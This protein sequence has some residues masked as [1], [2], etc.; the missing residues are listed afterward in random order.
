MGGAVR[1]LSN[2]LP[3]LAQS[4]PETTYTVLLREN[5]PVE[6]GAPN[7]TIERVANQVAA[8]W[9][10]RLY[11][12]LVVLPRRLKQYD[13]SLIVSLTNFGPVWTSVPHIIFQ[14]NAALYC[15]YYLG[16]VKGSLRAKLFLRRC[17][18]L[19]SM[20]SAQ[21]IVTPSHSMAD[22]I[23]EKC[24]SLKNRQ[25]EVLYHGFSHRPAL[26]NLDG[27]VYE[28]LLARST[29][30]I[31][32]PTHAARHKGFEILFKSLALLKRVYSKRFCLFA[33]IAQEDWP[34]GVQDFRAMVE[35]LGLIENVV[36]TGRVAQDQMGALYEAC[37]LMVYP[38]LSESFGFS[39]I[40][41]M[42]YGLPIVAG[43]TRI[44][45][46][47]CGTAALYYDAHNAADAAE[48]IASAMGSDQ[49]AVLR[50]QARKRISSF[51]W[52]WSRY[53]TEFV[54]LVDRCCTTGA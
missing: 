2:F 52:S 50:E 14:R 39:M 30:K 40:E 18:A 8:G 11:F 23:R 5:A 54:R 53:A 4:D 26:N 43:N 25:I 37:D 29:F 21:L 48:K 16:L 28:Q 3:A 36:F 34:K 13:Y 51:D 19:A 20:R 17:I 31:L 47:V 27:M 38:S 7:I 33:T 1:H 24:P 10:R 41:A 32:Y 35:R 45:Q 42:G 12:D 15:P 46:E 22:M 6:F 44:N 9:R 49:R